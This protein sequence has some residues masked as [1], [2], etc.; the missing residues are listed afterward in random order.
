MSTYPQTSD[1]LDQEGSIITEYNDMLASGLANFTSVNNGV[2]AKLIDTSVAFQT[3]IDDP[4]AYGAP[5]A[6]CYNSDGTSCL[7]YN[8][9]HPGIAINEL[10]AEEIAT[11][12]EG[13]FF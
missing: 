9:Y 4:T 3:A 12:W 8:N 6:T 10:V 2:T 1:V 7:W 13:S 11:A 5:N